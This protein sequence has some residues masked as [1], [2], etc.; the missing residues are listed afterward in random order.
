MAGKKPEGLSPRFDSVVCPN[1]PGSFRFDWTFRANKTGDRQTKA[2]IKIY[3][4]ASLTPLK[5]ITVLG[6]DSFYELASDTI[7]WEQQQRYVWEVVSYDSLN[8]A[9]EPSV[10]ATFYYLESAEANQITWSSGPEAYEN[11][12]PRAYFN[13]ISTNLLEVLSDYNVDSVSEQN[14]YDLVSDK[15]FVGDV[16]PSRSDFVLLEQAIAFLYSKEKLK[17][18]EVDSLIENGIGAGD[19]HKVYEFI[20]SLLKVDPL[21]PTSISITVPV[22]SVPSMSK[23]T[24]ISSGKNDQTVDVQWDS[25]PIEDENAI[26]TISGFSSSEDV[27]YYICEYAYGRDDFPY[28]SKMYYR[29]SDFARINNRIQP[30]LRYDE[31]FTAST[32]EKSHHSFSIKAVDV[33]GNESATFNKTVKA[34]ATFKTPL[35]LAKYEVE[36]QKAPLSATYPISTRVYVDLYTGT[37][38]SIA[39]KLSKNQEGTYFYRARYVDLSGQVGDWKGSAGNKFDPLDPP[40]VPKNLSGVAGYNDI[41]WKWSEVPTADGYKWK[42]GYGGTEH[43]TSSEKGSSTGLNEDT[44]YTLYVRAYNKAGM[45]GW[46]SKKIST[47]N[48]PPV[49]YEVDSEVADVWR[50]GYYYLGRHQAGGWYTS[51]PVKEQIIQGMWIELR[52]GKNTDGVW[53]KKGQTYGNHKSLIYLNKSSW[54]TRLAGKEIKK[55]ELYLKRVEKRHG[56]PNDGRYIEV[57]THNYTSKPSNEPVLSNSTK[58]DTN[59]GRGEGH[60]ITLPVRYG[61]LLRDGKIG[62]V[63][64]HTNFRTADTSKY[65]YCRF[66][67]NSTKFRITYE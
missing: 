56:Y 39:H 49:R 2:V 10:R 5:T 48:R 67:E 50:T 11:M 3:E 38:K 55:V 13:T 53:V 44:D 9:S 12:G 42:I 32:M 61:E 23:A 37:N 15:L 43:I 30:F 19:I 57:W 28:K 41:S 47:K 63:A 6:D 20:N 7:I 65:T 26:I 29:S 58:I 45:S 1:F 17:G 64:L 59:F 54:Q 46:A 31:F 22:I 60:W 16:I 34:P 14:I 27:W 35:G 18:P 36:Y 40:P 8:I 33:R 21:P 62:G 66:D 51:G 25:N 24:F 4:D 52:D